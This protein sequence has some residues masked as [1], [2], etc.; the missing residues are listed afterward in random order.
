MPR[1]RKWIKGFLFEEPIRHSLTLEGVRLHPQRHRLELAPTASGNFPLDLDMYARTRV[2][3]PEAC[4]KWSGFMAFTSTPPGTL[5]RFRLNDGATDRYWNGGANAWTPAAPNNWN[6][7]QEVADH[8]GEWSSQS[9]AVVIMLATLDPKLTPHVTEVRLLFDTDL[10][11]LEDY[12]VRSYLEELRTQFRAISILAVTSTGQ[13]SIDL[14]ALQTPYEIV[15]VDAVYNN[16]SDPAHMNPVTGWSYNAGEKLLSIP[17]QPAGDR[18]EV[19]FVW[20]PHVVLMQSQDYTEIPRIPA[21]VVEDVE[22]LT[23]AVVRERPYVINKGTGQ[24]FAFENGYQADIAVPLKLIASG[25]RDLHVMGEEASRFFAN[26]PTIRVRGQDEWYPIV[27]DTG[28]DDSS[29]ATQK[30]LYSARIQARIVNAVFYPEDARP[31]TG[32][33]RFAVTGGPIIEVP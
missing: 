18:I 19:R 26:N 10:V 24:G 29:T 30:E 33:L 6:T 17:A 1:Y 28:F 14:K 3:T 7:E 22:V 21:I 4:R 5:V 2:T 16:A 13:T 20:R 27:D 32:V 23:K 31:I 15:E 11:Q 12:V 9:L 25:V 8:I